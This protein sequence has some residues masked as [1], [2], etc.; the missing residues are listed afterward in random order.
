MSNIK[1]SKKEIILNIKAFNLFFLPQS[2][3]QNLK[4]PLPLLRKIEE[5]KQVSNYIY[6]Y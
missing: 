6:I 2:Q 4:D 3:P 5:V 1:F